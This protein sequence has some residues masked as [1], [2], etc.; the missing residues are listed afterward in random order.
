[1]GETSVI[2]YGVGTMGQLTARLLLERGVRITGAIGRVSNVGRDLGE[3]IGWERP[4]GIKIVADPDEVLGKVPADVAILSVGET[5]EQAFPYLERCV[6]AGVTVFSL[7]EQ[8]F[9]PWHCAPGLSA[10][11]DA[12]AKARGVTVGAGGIQDV[13]WVNLIAV[14]SGASQSITA[15]EGIAAA[16]ADDYG[17]AVAKDA[18][19]GEAP[20]SFEGAGEDDGTRENLFTIVLEAIAAELGFTIAG[21]KQGL[22]LLVAEKPVLCEALGRVVEPG[23]VSGLAT[24]SRVATEE[25]A[26]L[27]GEIH[28]KVFDEG[29]SETHTWVIR[30]EPTL[31]LE[32]RELPGPVATCTAVVNRIPDIIAAEPGLVTVER[33][34][35]PKFKQRIG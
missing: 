18:G 20:E 28:L 8:V 23:Q 26:E 5:M 4:L 22:R 16:N 21:W 11:I 34:P 12:L 2:I 32:C 29:D 13:F 15:I 3:V 14:L 17:P 33:L 1:M 9:F 10:D 6:A 35:K 25:G 7:S 30:G 19:I 31:Q 27:S 24:W